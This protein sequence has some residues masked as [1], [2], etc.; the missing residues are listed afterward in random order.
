MFTANQ[1]GRHQS[2]FGFT[3]HLLSAPLLGSVGGQPE[4]DQFKGYLATQLEVL[5][6]RSLAEALV[7]RMNLVE[8]PEFASANWFST[9]WSWFTGDEDGGRSEDARKRSVASQI[10]G[11]VTVKPVKQSNLIQISITG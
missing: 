7:T 5:K 8:H 10:V 11:R 3:E 9:L 6:S 1:G 2:G 4:Y